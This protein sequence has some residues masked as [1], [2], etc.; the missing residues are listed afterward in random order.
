[1][2]APSPRAARPLV[3]CSLSCGSLALQLQLQLPTAF[4][5]LCQD[6]V[7][8]CDQSVIQ[9]TV[10]SHSYMLGRAQMPL[11]SPI[12]S[13]HEM[14]SCHLLCPVGFGVRGTGLLTGSIIYKL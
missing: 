3:T 8:S 7:H 9:Q 4:S 5:S 2:T 14:P 13:G 10:L 6:S 1:M 12:T 11:G